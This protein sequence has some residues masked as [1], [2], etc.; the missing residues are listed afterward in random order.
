MVRHRRLGGTTLASVKMKVLRSMG[1]CIM[2]CFLV[3]SSECG[4]S[5]WSSHAMKCCL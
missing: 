3:F 1:A 5:K 2:A 4:K